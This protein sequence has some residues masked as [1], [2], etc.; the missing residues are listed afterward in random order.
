MTRIRYKK[1][2]NTLV[3][4]KPILCNNR[5][6]IIILNTET[7]KYELVDATTK[8]ILVAGISSSVQGLKKSAKTAAQ[9]IGAKFLDELR[10]GKSERKLIVNE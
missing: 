10:N 8:E 1:Q 9:T 5:L 4:A 2:D 7:M 3:S 6:A